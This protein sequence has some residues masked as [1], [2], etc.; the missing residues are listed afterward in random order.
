MT[1]APATLAIR[2]ML[3]F[4]VLAV[5]PL[6][7]WDV[8]QR[9]GVVPIDPDRGTNLEGSMLAFAVAALAIGALAWRLPAALP[10]R[11]AR[12]AV[13]VGTYVPFALGWVALLVGYLRLVAC[14][15]QPALD[16]LATAPVGRPGFWVVVFA[17]VVAAPFAEEVV[18]RGYLQGALLGVL[19]P[20]VA[21][22]LT[23]V[24]FG[25][26]HGLPYALPLALLGALFG[27]IAYRCRSLGASM[28]AHAL[29]NGL[30][31]L[32]TVAWPGSLDFLYRR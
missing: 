15:P 6:L 3:G 9:C 30:T 1:A 19:R 16:Y 5:G 26:A 20:P 17:I 21:I 23:A 13:V 12:A 25:L 2:F 11:P 29:H 31:V 22:G 14:E 27:A 8:L 18:F 32:V 10:F 4:A 28:F 7:V 24:V